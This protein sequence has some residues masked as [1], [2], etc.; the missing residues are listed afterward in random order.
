MDGI[1]QQ[2]WIPFTPIDDGKYHPTFQDFRFDVRYNVTKK[3]VV[4]TPFVG[5]IV[6]SHDY[7]YFGHSAV[8]RDLK[9]LQ[10]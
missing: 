3:G 2:Y 9:E 8:G 10:V 1:P 6:P 5:S 4:L 7:A